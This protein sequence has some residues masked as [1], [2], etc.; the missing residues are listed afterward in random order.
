MDIMSALLLLKHDGEDPI[1]LR[2]F[3]QGDCQE[4]T[5]HKRQVETKQICRGT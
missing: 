2:S 1:P 3:I 5:W 4:D